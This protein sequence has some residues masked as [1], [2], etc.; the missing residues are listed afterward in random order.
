MTPGRQADHVLRHHGALEPGRRGGLPEPRVPHLRVGDQLRRRGA[1]AD[2][3]PRGDRLRLRPRRCSSGASRRRPSSSSSTRRRTRRAACSSRGRRP[4]R[5]ARAALPDPGAVRR[6]LPALPLRRRVRLDRRA[7]GHE[8]SDDHPGRLL[9]DLRD[10]RL[11]ARL[12]RDA[13]AA[14]RAPHAAHDEL[15]LLHRDLHP[16][17]RHRRAPG[18]TDAGADDGGGVPPAP[19]PDRRR[20]QPRSPA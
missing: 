17:R 15:R 9:E 19:R 11:A 16:A 14:R 5:R 6:D 12:R 18:A 8:D 20:A 13:E 10:D 2:P 4:D 1:G 7:A 3:A